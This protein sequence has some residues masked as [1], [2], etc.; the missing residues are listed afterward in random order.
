MAGWICQN[1]QKGTKMNYAYRVYKTL[2][3]PV[4]GGTVTADSMDEAAQKV[5]KRNKIDVVHESHNGLEY[6][7]FMLNGNKIGI[8]VYANPENF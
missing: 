5:I 2:S 8:L 3:N 6:H 7:Y 1:I 4:F